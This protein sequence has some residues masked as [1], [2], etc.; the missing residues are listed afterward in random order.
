[1]TITTHVEAL[2]AAARRHGA[3]QADAILIRNEAEAA[4]V[5]KGVPED[6]ERSEDVTLGL[7]VFR[8]KRAAAVSTSV[9]DEREFDRLAEQACAMALVV[10]EDRFA[11]LAP[12]ALTGHFDAT[13]LDLD[14][15]AQLDMDALLAHA[16]LAEEVALSHTG[17][18][19]TNGASAS[20]GRATVVLGTSAGFMGCY[21]R[22]SHSISASVLAGEGPSMQRDY[23]YHSAVHLSDLDAPE[24][25]GQEA[26]ERVLARLSPG[27]P[28]TGTYS[29]IYDPRVSSTLLG[30]LVAGI[31]GAA[32]ARGTSFLKDAMKTRVLGAGLRVHDDP[33]R[34]RGP[35]SRPFDGEG[36]F[37]GPLDLV[38][39]GILQT[40]L[41]DS[42]SGRQLDLP[43]NGR[44][45]RGVTSPPSPS[46]TN[47]HLAAGTL[48]PEALRSDI[49]EGILVTEL[50]GSSVNMLT[51]DYS[52][53]ASGFMI[54]NGE[55]AEPVAELTI[56]G[57]LRDM[58]ARM[59]PA[60]DLTFRRSVNAPS[61]RIDGMNIAGL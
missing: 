40:L 35:A 29:V 57:N 37:A 46:V 9:L 51:G 21:S 32:V 16:R 49:R 43:S 24:V 30:H 27:R 5:R 28:K 61:L 26:A 52:R 3:D 23:A 22:T 34:P 25:I 60:S 54:R 38:E 20:R 4:L 14:D 50:M 53:G 45:S 41:L 15:P 12:N 18:T 11:G 55:I 56:A 17:I 59:V 10:P 8:G 58:L 19:N 6:I 7:R 2:L 31:N 1:M 39:D 36:C 48:S 33:R 44:A 13:G 47:L 42:R